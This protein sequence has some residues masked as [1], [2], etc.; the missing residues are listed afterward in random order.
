MTKRLVSWDDVALTLPAVVDADLAATYG[1]LSG[2]V[3][4]DAYS[5]LALA[6]AAVPANGVLFLN[7][8]VTYPVNTTLTPSAN[9]VTIDGLGASIRIGAAPTGTASTADN[10]IASGAFTG[11][12]LRNIQFLTPL[13]GSHGSSTVAA[14]VNISASGWRVTECTSTTG[15]L[16]FVYNTGSDVEID[17]NVSNGSGIGY[18]YSGASRVKCHHN[19]VLSAIQGS[20][21]LSNALNGVGNG[22]GGV[23]NDDCEVFSNYVVSPQ[24][25]GIEDQQQTRNTKIHHN[26]VILSA[27]QGISCNGIAPTVSDNTVIDCGATMDG[28]ELASGSGICANNTVEYRTVTSA[29]YGIIVDGGSSAYADLCTVTGNRVVKAKNGIGSVNAAHQVVIM[30]NTVIEAIANGIYTTHTGLGASVTI[31]GNTIRFLAAATV[32]RMGITVAYVPLATISANTIYYG[33][34]TRGTGIADGTITVQTPTMLNANILDAVDRT[35]AAPTDFYGISTAGG[36]VAGIVFSGNIFTGS[37]TVTTTGMTYRAIGN[38]GL[39]D[40]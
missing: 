1:R 16:L 3:Y 34:S 33:A 38:T 12:T 40:H 26:T 4:A 13:S 10:I 36:T 2:A 39:A 6:L 31:T 25:M 5:T 23:F 32:Q 27:T 28:I 17:H 29:A 7:Q 30:G 15:S 24:R 22:G 9:G 19:Q 11:G 21:N 35:T 8:T 18:A 20:A 37:I 14:A